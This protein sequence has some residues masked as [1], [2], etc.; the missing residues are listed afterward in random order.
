MLMVG[1]CCKN[2]IA[3]YVATICN[4]MDHAYYHAIPIRKPL[5]CET[6]LWL[7]GNSDRELYENTISSLSPKVRLA[8]SAI[9]RNCSTQCRNYKSKLCGFL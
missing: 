5:L 8:V 7:D 4:C 2:I 1:P 3:S 9:Y 6:F